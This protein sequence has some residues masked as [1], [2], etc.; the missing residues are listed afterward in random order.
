LNKWGFL[1]SWGRGYGEIIMAMLGRLCQII[2]LLLVLE[3]LYFGI[4][5]GSMGK[6]MGFL[7]IGGIVFYI[8][9]IIEGRAK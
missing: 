1:V 8:G 4:F 3:A 2:G 9:R 7:V 6:E 5:R